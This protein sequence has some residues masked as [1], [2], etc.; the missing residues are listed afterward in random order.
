MV[1]VCYSKACKSR[2][3]GAVLAAGRTVSAGLCAGFESLAGFS[4]ELPDTR[5]RP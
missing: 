4:R 1:T 2:N 5:L 3:Y